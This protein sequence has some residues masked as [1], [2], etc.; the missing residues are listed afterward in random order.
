MRKK[1]CQIF[2]RNGLQVTIEA[3]SKTVNFLDITLDLRTG[4][5]KPFMKENDTPV[6]VSSRSNHPALVLKNIP[7]GVNR[8]LSRIS[9]NKEIFE[10]AA[11]PYQQALD[12]SGYKHTLEFEVPSLSLT[13][14]KNRRRRVTWFNPPFSLSVK[15]N[16]GREFLDLL[17]RAFP[18]ENSLHK[19]F[20]RQT[21]KIS[22][23]CMPNMGTLVARHNSKVLREDQ[24]AAQPP[25]CKCTGGV[26]NCPVQ[27]ACSQT[28]V[29]YQASVEEKPSGKIETYTGLTGRPFKKR[30]QEHKRDF[31]KPQNRTKS[32]L[33]GYIWDLKDNG[34]DFEITWKI[35]EKAQTFNP[36]NKKCMLCLKEKYFI[37]YRTEG[38]TLN[39]RSEIFNTCRHRT[40]SLLAKVKS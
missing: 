24:P 12:K 28:G 5:Y 26:V 35:L 3:N 23:K 40:Q 29:V 9:A 1:I 22:Y 4:D 33:S 34:L 2:N 8:R 37:M 16:V 31:V 25:R 27:G 36:V 15:T 11:P 30:W 38:S 19:L 7:M 14:R 39:K 20:S 13:R 32:K 6:Y 21:V 18:P 17:D 10:A